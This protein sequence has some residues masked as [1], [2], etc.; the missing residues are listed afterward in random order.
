M[1]VA[2]YHYMMPPE[3]SKEYIVLEK[4]AISIYKEHGCL[5]VEIYRNAKDPRWWMEINRYKNREHY[6]EVV[7]AVDNDPRMAPLFVKFLALFN[8]K[9]NKPEKTTY[10]RIL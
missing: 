5:D 9:E 1:F 8:E 10:Y 3:K 2:I 4:K 6:N 7:T